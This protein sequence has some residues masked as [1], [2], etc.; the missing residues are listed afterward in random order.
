MLLCAPIH[1]LLC[2]GEW[3][4]CRCRCLSLFQFLYLSKW[5]KWIKRKQNQLIGMLML[6]IQFEIPLKFHTYLIFYLDKC[7]SYQFEIIFFIVVCFDLFVLFCLFLFLILG[8]KLQFFALQHLCNV[9]VEKVTIQN[10]LYDA[11]KNGN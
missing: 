1:V 11:S 6:A 4:R 8:W 3:Y 2:L 5:M 7:S 10:C 9:Q